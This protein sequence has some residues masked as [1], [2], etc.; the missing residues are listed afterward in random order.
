[1]VSVFPA[2]INSNSLRLRQWL[3]AE[4]IDMSTEIGGQAALSKQTVL[5][6]GSP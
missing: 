6:A 3:G 4:S 2:R 1:M 5:L